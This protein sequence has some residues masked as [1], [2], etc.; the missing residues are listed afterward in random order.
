MLEYAQL[1][2]KLHAR[3]ETI[4]QREKFSAELRARKRRN[5]ETL[6][7]VYHDV[8]RLMALAY[9]TARDEQLSEAIAKDYF[10]NALG[11]KNLEVRNKSGTKILRL[12]MT[13]CG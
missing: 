11:D 8:R 13:H 1:K 5:N 10:L 2:E 7:E 6:S 12:W 4:G 9:P 3:F